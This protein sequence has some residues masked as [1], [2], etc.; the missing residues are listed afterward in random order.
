MVSYYIYKHSW[1]PWVLQLTINVS[2]EKVAIYSMIRNWYPC[3]SIKHRCHVF[4]YQLDIKQR[5]VSESISACILG[6]VVVKSMKYHGYT[7]SQ[8][9]TLMVCSNTGWAM[10]WPKMLS[11]KVQRINSSAVSHDKIM[12][13]LSRCALYTTPYDVLSRNQMS[14]SRGNVT[15]FLMS[16]C[17]YGK[18]LHLQKPK[19]SVNVTTHHKCI[20]GKVATYL[21][22]QLISIDTN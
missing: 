16:W 11:L 9:T 18:L 20:N 1:R 2:M 3:I 5:F 15:T 4:P 8:V 7:D 12:F 19:A 13:Y 6:T 21:D 22:S 14:V 10:K 17:I